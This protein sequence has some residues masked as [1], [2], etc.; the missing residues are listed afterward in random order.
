VPINGIPFVWRASGEVCYRGAF[1][2]FLS[3]IATQQPIIDLSRIRRSELHIELGYPPA[4]PHFGP[5]PRENKRL[6]AALKRL[7]KLA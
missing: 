6:R 7:H 2:S 5:D 3:P 1:W 4:T